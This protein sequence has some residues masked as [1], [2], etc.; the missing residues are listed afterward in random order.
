LKLHG[1]VPIM[2]LNGTAAT[3]RTSRSEMNH[4]E[5]RQ[6]SS[7]VPGPEAARGLRS[8]AVVA[9][10]EGAQRAL[11]RAALLDLAPEA[12][13]DV[14]IQHGEERS[15]SLGA[16]LGPA[17]E[18]LK[19]RLQ[20]ARGRLSLI[21]LSADKDTTAAVERYC[22]QHR[23]ELVIIAREPKGVLSRLLGST[24]EKLARHG[25]V[26]ILIVQLPAE[27]PYRRVLV[28][29]DYSQA[30]H[31]VLELALR[32]KAPGAEPVDV[33]HCYDTSY[34]LVMHQTGAHAGQLVSYYE[35]HLLEAEATL[36]DFLKPT[37][38]GGANLH[39]LV[40]SGDPRAELEAA[41]R[42]Q[43][44]ELLVV[45]KHARQGLGHTLLGSVAESS[46][47]RAECD[48]LIVPQAAPTWH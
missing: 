26:P 35:K 22:E 32:M 44:T 13:V 41:A 18:R 37:L 9:T 2:R 40:K 6:E 39:L 16:R 14:L 11:T 7:S 48:V 28:G 1:F 17:G 43:G 20:A 36:R 47:R 8:V 46:L 23:P 25:Q 10:A 15:G 19:A 30:S 27:H 12:R 4:Q 21:S 5:P 29:I 33:L 31:G 3:V 24:P 42:E 45:G 34:S 38:A